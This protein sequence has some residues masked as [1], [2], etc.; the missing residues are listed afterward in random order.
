[1]AATC[2]KACGRFGRLRRFRVF[3]FVPWRLDG[4]WRSR[5]TDIDLLA[6]AS[7]R[8]AGRDCWKADTRSPK[9]RTKAHRIP[10]K[11]IHSQGDFSTLL[12]PL[13]C[14]NCG[15]AASVGSAFSSSSKSA[16]AL[17]EHG[18]SP[19][20]AGAQCGDPATV[21]GAE[22]SW[23]FPGVGLRRLR[24]VGF[25]DFQRLLH[26]PI[27][28]VRRRET[29]IPV[30]TSWPPIPV[31]LASYRNQVVRHPWRRPPGPRCER[32]VATFRIV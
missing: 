11:A 10:A 6:R 21:A 13:R 7:W 3:F 22:F 19:A 2:R 15:R 14:L 26:Q 20:V 31:C 18:G 8:E 28:R 29:P 23:L 27:W 30:R 32:V 9:T 4:R 17:R 25:G 5:R 24:A 12:A 1:M 16:F